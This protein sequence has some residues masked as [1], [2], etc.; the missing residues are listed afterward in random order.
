MLKLAG[1]SS[2]VLY[3]LTLV[4]LKI[5]HSGEERWNAE[6]VERVI[7]LAVRWGEKHNVPLVCDEFGV[8]RTFAP[9]NAR[10][11]WIE[12]VRT[13]LERH[14]LGWTMWDYAGDFGVAVKK[15]GRATPHP[16]TIAAL[17]LQAAK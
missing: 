14:G 9:T 1:N 13:A 8:Y 16:Q 12:D 10:L 6:R 15:E 7:A 11:R 17:G 5:R 2:R 4:L 3:E